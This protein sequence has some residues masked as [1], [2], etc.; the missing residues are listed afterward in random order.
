MGSFLKS[1]KLNGI[2]KVLLLKEKISSTSFSHSTL[3]VSLSIQQ[4]HNI[5]RQMTEELTPPDST[6]PMHAPLQHSP[7][8]HN[9]CYKQFLLV[10][11]TCQHP[12]CP[13]P[14]HN[15]FVPEAM[16]VQV[17]PRL[18]FVLDKIT[19]FTQVH[20]VPRKTHASLSGYSRR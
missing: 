8:C 4:Q 13:H 14:R 2:C 12:V 9:S 20:F 10:Q 11:R 16:A 6:K 3:N 5:L 7:V 19:R 18:C 15:G 17:L 1:K